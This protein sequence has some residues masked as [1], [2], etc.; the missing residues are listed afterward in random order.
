MEI[1]KN[2]DWFIMDYQKLSQFR[3]HGSEQPILVNTMDLNPPK[4]YYSGGFFLRNNK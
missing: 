2:N 4:N 3:I 1:D